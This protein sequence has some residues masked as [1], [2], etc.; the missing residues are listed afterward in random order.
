[1]PAADV[2]YLCDAANRY[3][4]EH[5]HPT[6][7]VRTI[8]GVNLTPASGAGEPRRHG[9]FHHAGARRR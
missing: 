9:A 5:L 6:D 7:V 3:F 4:R 1:M 8:S 2:G